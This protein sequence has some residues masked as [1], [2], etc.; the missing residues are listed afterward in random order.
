M[1]SV[2]DGLTTTQ[3]ARRLGVSPQR[4]IQLVRAGHLPH[5]MTAHGRLYDPAAVE[6]LAAQRQVERGQHSMTGG[7]S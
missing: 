1:I 2:V 6:R 5:V 3:V 7:G 4:V